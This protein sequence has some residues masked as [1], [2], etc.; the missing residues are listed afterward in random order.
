MAR[1]LRCG[2]PGR[3]SAAGAEL[4]RLH[5]FALP[6]TGRIDGGYEIGAWSRPAR[7]IGGDLLVA[8][9]VPGAGLMVF[10]GDVMGHGTPAAVV[11]SALRAALHQLR[12]AGVAGPAAILSRLNEV[13]C[14]LFPEYFVTASAALL[15]AGGLTCAQAGHPALLV[16]PAAGR[17]VNVPFRSLPLGLTPGG[18]YEEKRLG[19]PAGATLLLYSDGVLDALAQ[20]G[21]PPLDALAEVVRHSRGGGARGLVQAVRQAVRRAGRDRHDDRA[22]LAVRRL[23]G[24][25]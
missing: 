1:C 8:W 25:E 15:A 20:P 21:R 10:L 4:A 22:V 9:D 24:G 19:L 18:A 7:H 23:P 2:E 5:D 11:A 12:Q 13:V 17:V 6:L 14:D 16:R 3:R